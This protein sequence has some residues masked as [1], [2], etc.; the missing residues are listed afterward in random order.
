VEETM[1]CSDGEPNVEKLLNS[2]ESQLRNLVKG[3]PTT[4]RKVV[5]VGGDNVGP[6]QI[7]GECH[8]RREN[9]A[10]SNRS[11]LTA[12]QL[13]TDLA[14]GAPESSGFQQHIRRNW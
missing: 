2:I 1:F 4:I 5:R 14:A 10:C 12:K 8:Q 7:C 3:M 6:N 11:N 9:C 13:G